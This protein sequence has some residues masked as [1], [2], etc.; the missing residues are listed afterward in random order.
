MCWA[1]SSIASAQGQEPPCVAQ[2]EGLEQLGLQLGAGSRHA[3]QG[4]FGAAHQAVAEKSVFSR[5]QAVSRGRGFSA[6]ERYPER[7]MTLSRVA[8]LMP[9]TSDLASN[10]I[11]KFGSIGDATGGLV[12]VE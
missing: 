10:S 2:A 8:T 12:Q 9:R 11:E 5:D 7:C 1:R 4:G 3:D 6:G